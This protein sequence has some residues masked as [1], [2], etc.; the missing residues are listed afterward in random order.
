MTRQKL[1][2]K[3]TSIIQ[4]IPIEGKHLDWFSAEIYS[5]EIMKLWDCGF[6]YDLPEA[7]RKP[8]QSI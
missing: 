6:A 1:K 2:D 7:S 8:L 5:E 3:I 4:D